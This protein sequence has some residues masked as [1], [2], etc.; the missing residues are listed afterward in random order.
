M[1][2]RECGVHIDY[3]L[4]RV[5]EPRCE[6]KHLLGRWVRC[7]GIIKH[8]YLSISNR[9][10]ICNNDERHNIPK[11]TRVK[12]MRLYP[13]GRIC[14]SPPYSWLVEGPPCSLNHIDVITVE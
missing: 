10:P 1:E 5:D 4:L 6:N 7:N 2:C 13:D 9:C 14:S 12:C 8:V 11:G 3:K